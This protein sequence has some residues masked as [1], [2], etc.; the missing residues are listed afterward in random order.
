MLSHCDCRQVGPKCAST[1]SRAFNPSRC[2]CS[3]PANTSGALPPHLACLTVHTTGAWHQK[4]CTATGE[5]P[6]VSWLRGDAR[7]RALHGRRGR[8]VGVGGWAMRLGEAGDVRLILPS[9]LLRMLCLRSL[10]R[11]EVRGAAILLGGWLRLVLDHFCQLSL[12][13]CHVS[14]RWRLPV[15]WVRFVLQTCFPTLRSA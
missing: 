5:S 1:S 2:S 3:C 6:G 12:R 4:C 13:L 14:E 9:R 8:D 11:L 7:G 15:L 10:L